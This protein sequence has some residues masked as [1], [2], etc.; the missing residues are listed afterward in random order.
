MT[1]VIA[2]RTNT[3]AA[4]QHLLHLHGLKLTQ[5][6]EDTL[7][8]HLADRLVVN[9][10]LGRGHEAT[11]VDDAGSEADLTTYLAS[12]Y[13][14]SETKRF[15]VST[16]GS[17]QLPQGASLLTKN[18]FSKRTWNVTQQMLLQRDDPVYAEQLARH[19]AMDRND[20][21][22]DDGDRENPYSRA[23]FNLTQQMLL[24][25]NDPQR[26]ETLRRAAGVA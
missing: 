19:A 7:A 5:E 20:H 3:A 21:R 9:R 25:R 10:V 23:G 2:G 4:L 12:L 22:G 13:Q 17:I 15:F 6:G 18:P 26:A 14:G 11:Y 8:E 24:E 16:G 1:Q